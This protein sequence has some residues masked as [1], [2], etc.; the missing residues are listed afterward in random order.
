MKSSPSHQ[1]YLQYHVQ[2]EKIF[3]LKH[4]KYDYVKQVTKWR[5]QGKNLILRCKTSMKNQ[6]YIQLRFINAHVFRL[7]LTLEESPAEKR[8]NILIKNSQQKVSFNV[9]DTGH[10][11][12]INSGAMI[13]NIEKHPW[14]L[15][16][17]DA[18]EN[19]IFSQNVY[20]E[21]RSFFPNYNL[22][23]RYQRKKLI[24]CYESIDLRPDEHIYGL[25]EKFDRLDKVGLHTVAWQSDTTHTVTERAYKN[26]PFFMSNY[27]Y[28]LF[29]HTS[30]RIDY[31]IGSAS[32]V[33]TSFMVP[34]NELQYYFIY[35]PSFKQILYRYTELTGRAPMPPRWSFGLWM[36]RFSYKNR[37]ELES[38]CQQLREYEVPCDVVHIDPDW[39]RPGHYCDLVW[40]EQAWPDR[41]EMLSK[42]H[43]QG[44][45]IS[46]WEQPY[47]KSATD[48]FTEGAKK[49]F[50][51]KDKDGQVYLQSDFEDKPAAFVDFSNPKAARWYQTKHRKLLEEGADVFKTDMGEA[52]PEDA[53]FH[54][55]M[56]GAEMHNLYPLLYNRTVFEAVDKHTKGKGLVWGRS[57]WAGSQRYPL[58]WAGD[59]H[60]TFEDMAC[61]LRAGLSYG[62]SGVPFWSHDIGGFQG[63]PPSPEL[64]IRWAQ[65]GLLCSHS[66]CHGVGPREPWHFGEQALRIFKKYANLR[67]QLLPYLWATAFEATQTGLP[68]IR[69]MGLEF[70]ADPNA[71][72]LDLQYLLG[73]ALLIAP[74]LN[75]YGE[76]T[77][78]LP[79]GRWIDYWSKK[80]I[81]GSVFQKL[82]VDLETIP[83]Y[84]R[85]NSILPYGPPM[86]YVDEK[87]Q[88][89]LCFEIFVSKWAEITLWNEA[90]TRVTAERNHEALRIDSGALTGKLFY[91]IYDIDEPKN[92]VK[93]D[94][95]IEA[96][97][98]MR[99]FEISSFVWFYQAEKRTLL[100]K[101]ENEGTPFSIEIK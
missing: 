86:N 79:E 52:V 16:V 46:L 73:H 82:N 51:A 28:G 25:G 33:A 38:I 48:R 64:Y 30:H 80:I 10:T 22:G 78:Y 74:V 39:M 50:F 68:V 23:F 43:K 56:T 12:H 11:L 81:S 63:P 101:C 70:Q 32:Y 96:V 92:V 65:F 95:P 7:W 42:L 31:E 41:K 77:V 100:I 8:S 71:W 87:P 76:V 89:P 85:E 84:I 9:T 62:I 4:F 27:G 94:T 44:F 17:Q 21:N 15:S 47:V 66:R 29:I 37:D 13:I 49:G 97:H 26:I 90:E 34:S 93:S 67:Y 1:K 91:T 57:G 53:H 61:T 6:A 2:P 19:R 5:K 72:H 98:E 75:Q 20:G 54:N 36:S 69:P 83:I 55:G 18:K 24:G 58:N 99:D 35:G 88:N 40:N 60:S 45:H 14:C 59:S 3:D